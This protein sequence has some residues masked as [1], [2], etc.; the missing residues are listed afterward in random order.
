LIE[1]F[2]HTKL[3]ISEFKTRCARYSIRIRGSNGYAG[4]D[5]QGETSD[6][7]V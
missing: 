3:R 7:S 1:I 6:G 5:P 4:P 2:L